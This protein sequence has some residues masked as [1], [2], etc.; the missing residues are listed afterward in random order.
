MLIEKKKYFEFLDNKNKDCINNT[1]KNLFNEK[2]KKKYPKTNSDIQI[3]FLIDD[4]I[5]TKNISCYNNLLLLFNSFISFEDSL[6]LFNIIKVKKLTDT[7]I[8]SSLMH[9][10]IIKAIKNKSSIKSNLYS[11]SKLEFGFEFIKRNIKKLGDNMVYLDIGCGDG[12]KTTKFSKVFKIKKENINGTDIKTWGPY[13]EKKDLP[14]NFKYIQKNEKLDYPDESF[15]IITCILTLHHIENINNMLSEIYRILKKNG[16][17]ILIEH[18]GLTYNDQLII[19]IQHSMFAFLY[20][21]NKN[22]IKEPYYSCYLNN[23][24]FEYILTK[25][26]NFKLLYFDNYYQTIDLQKRYDQQFYQIYTK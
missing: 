23:M 13:E 22:Y 17:F 11:C 10:Y 4:L 25:K 2:S 20:D 19:D 9:T 6:K 15:D 1:Y 16:I 3:K 21:N 18:D 14:F 8:I 26:F 5:A 24:E 7:E 12:R